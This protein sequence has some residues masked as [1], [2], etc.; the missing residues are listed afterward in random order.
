MP[1][2]QHPPAQI[3]AGAPNAHGSYLGCLPRSSGASTQ[4][5]HPDTDAESRL[6]A[7]GSRVS[8]EICSISSGF[9]D[10]AAEA[11]TTTWAALRVETLSVDLRFAGWRGTGN[12]RE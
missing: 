10:S 3:R 1:V 5:A 12:N 6:P 2:T 11:A 8:P 4:S 9:V 7:A